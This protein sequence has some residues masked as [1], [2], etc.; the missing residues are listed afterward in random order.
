M[1]SF[2]RSQKYT[3]A[4]LSILEHLKNWPCLYM[5]VYM[6]H[7]TSDLMCYQENSLQ[8]PNRYVQAFGNFIDVELKQEK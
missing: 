8:P 7:N 1:L 6:H 3:Q 4:T 2:Y 5:Y